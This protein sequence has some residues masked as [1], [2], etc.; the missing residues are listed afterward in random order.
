V[1]PLAVEYAG[2][3]QNEADLQ[4]KIA[5]L[6][7]AGTRWVWVVRLSGP[8]RVE[9]Y[10]LERPVH[11]FTHGEELT[12]PGVLRNPVAVDALFVREASHEAVLRNLLQRRGYEGLDDVRAEGRNEGRDEGR[13]EGERRGLTEAVAGLCDVLDIP[14]TDERRAAVGRLDVAG[15]RALVDRL[16]RDRRWE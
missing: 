7:A 11:T 13:D 12:A 15:L 6:L 2:P 16:R 9:V 8:R 5:D 10:E 3:T 1:P 14:L 4:T